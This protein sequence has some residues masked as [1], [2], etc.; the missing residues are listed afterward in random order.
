MLIKTEKALSLNSCWTMISIVALLVIAPIAAGSSA[1]ATNFNFTQIDV[2][3]ATS[4]FV[5]G[6]N[7]VGQIVGDFFDSTGTHGFLAT[8]TAA[9]VPEPSTLTLLS[10]GIGLTG[11]AMM[12]RRVISPKPL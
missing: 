3:G 9:P 8:P 1:N 11:I 10:I 7:D 4:T 2:P 6:I 12:R 5:S